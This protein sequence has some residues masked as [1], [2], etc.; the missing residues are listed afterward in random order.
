MNQPKEVLFNEYCVK[1]KYYNVK[2]ADDP[3]C[4]CLAEPSNTDS[5]KPV[6]F[7]EGNNN[8]RKCSKR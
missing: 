7:E 4:D 6:Y 5:H 1:C 2:E 3:C 8:V